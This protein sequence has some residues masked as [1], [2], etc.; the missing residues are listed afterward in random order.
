MKILKLSPYFPPEQVS[1]T[2][3]TDDLNQA[4]AD[5]GILQENFVPMPTRGVSDSVRAQYKNRKYEE[6][7]DGALIVHRFLMFREGKNS[8]QR[9][10]RYGLVNVIQYFMGIKAKKIDIVYSSSTPPTQG[11]LCGKVAKKLSK[12][13]GKHVPFIYCLQDV[14][15]DSLV[16]TGMTSK[17]SLIWKIGRKIENKTYQYADRIIVISDDIRNN[18]IEKG[19][20]DNKII[21]IPNWVDTDVV[22][23]INKNENGLFSE[24]HIP[25]DKF[26]IVYA[27][28]LGYAQGIDTLLD[29]A[30]VL[31][32]NHDIQ[33]V[34]F[35]SG[36]NQEKYQLICQ[37]LKNVLLFPLMPPDRIAEVYS[38]GDLCLVA[39]RKGTGKG[40][41]PSKTFSIMASGSP[42][43]LS[44]DRD[45][46]LWNIINQNN[47]GLCSDA[48][49]INGLVKNILY[50]LEHKDSIT[51]M[52]ENARSLVE[53]KYSKQHGTCAYINL[54]EQ[55][56][57]K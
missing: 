40:A 18:I 12:K 57:A 8:I 44:F 56:L 15:P 2:H 29:A 36:N 21:V 42:V 38:M 20:P 32:D 22:F 53:K 31:K 16:S 54:F 43:L 5:S 28:N 23:P 45:T 41:V 14:F 11:L 35:G 9:A 3:L 4:F 17:G 19:V 50:A 49:D 47:C 27:G 25:K 1:S 24:L 33:F 13:R 26:T 39:C 51:V 30:S 7:Y 46:E 37:Q 34:I 52:G 48:E 6:L 55:V 10:F